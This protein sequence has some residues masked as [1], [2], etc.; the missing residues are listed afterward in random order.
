[1]RRLGK[2]DEHSIMTA[3]FVR[4]LMHAVETAPLPV[5]ALRHATRRNRLL[6]QAPV[7]VI[8]SVITARRLNDMLCHGGNMPEWTRCKAKQNVEIAGRPNTFD[9]FLRNC[10]D[11]T[12]LSVE[13]E[14]ANECDRYGKARYRGAIQDG[15]GQSVIAA[16]RHT[17]VVCVI[18]RT[19]PIPQSS[20][21]DYLELLKACLWDKFQIGLIVREATVKRTS[22]PQA[23][24]K[25]G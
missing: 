12:T 16:M 11:G 14:S 25:A 17:Y 8:Q 5:D 4:D 24:G 7:S 6:T 19:C 9:L 23:I 10:D 22:L 13:V 15:I 21:D 3:E 2:S 20:P 18:V 1:M